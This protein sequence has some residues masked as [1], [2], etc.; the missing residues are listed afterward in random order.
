VNGTL[1]RETGK[2]V[3]NQPLVISVDNRTGQTVVTDTDGTFAKELVN[4]NG[5]GDGESDAVS[6]PVNVS[7]PAVG[8]NLRPISQATTVDVVVDSEDSVPGSED[9]EKE[10]G[11]TELSLWEGLRQNFALNDLSFVVYALLAVG[12]LILSYVAV[13]I[14]RS[15][16]SAEQTTEPE[17]MDSDSKAITTDDTGG[18]SVESTVEHLNVDSP[19]VTVR[20]GYAALRQE[21]TGGAKNANGQTHWEFYEACREQLDSEARD[22]LR[23]VTGAYERVAFAGESVDSELAQ[24]VIDAVE[25]LDMSERTVTDGGGT[26]ES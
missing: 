7:F 18:I 23:V 4:L 3:T 13:R 20:V 17:Q 19:E 16:E 9:G 1:R 14:L 11:T 22:H 15:D 26:N 8:S 2:P 5:I 12:L 6:V 24:E 25:S 21:L 10:N